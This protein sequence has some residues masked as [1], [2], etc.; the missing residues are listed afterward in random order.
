MKPSRGCK[1]L[2]VEEFVAAVILQEEKEMKKK[3]G[4][5]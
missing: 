5:G 1:R 2:H 3:K 4:E